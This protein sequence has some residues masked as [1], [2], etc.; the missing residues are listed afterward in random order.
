MVSVS[1][2]ADSTVLRGWIPKQPYGTVVSYYLRVSSTD[3]LVTT[4]PPDTLTPVV[5]SV[6]PDTIPPRILHEPLPNRSFRDV[7]FE[8]AATLGDTNGI[9]S[10]GVTYRIDGG[11]D[12]TVSLVQ[13]S[14][15]LWSGSMSGN[16]SPGDIVEYRI[17]ATDRSFSRNVASLPDS[18]MFSFRI[19]NSVLYDFESSDGGFQS[20]ADWQW[21][22]IATTDVPAPPHGQKVWGTN[23]SG[24][25]SSNVVSDLISPAIDLTGKTNV[26]L[27]FKHFY[28]IEP[29]NDGGNVSISVDSGAFQVVSPEGGYPWAFVAALGGPGFSGNSFVWKDARFEISGMR[30]HAIRVR[31]RFASDLLTTQRGWYVDD[32]SMDFLDTAA[33]S[34]APSAGV[35]PTAT[36]LCQNYPNPFNPTT[37]ISFDIAVGGLVRLDVY[38][39]LG[40]EVARLKHEVLAPGSYRVTFNSAGLSSGTYLCRLA[41]GSFVE[42]R[43]L[44]ILR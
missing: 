34:V 41:V 28:N 17:E 38:D 20:T 5:F 35:F 19:L 15:E 7:P 44:M 40:R 29:Q 22:T 39:V 24:N 12:T 16:F 36:R 6:V 32:F 37:V 42:T 31:M 18:G 9:A 27:T 11:P 2:Q 13:L 1:S 10:A 21:G 33:V 26:V 43:K 8:V 23:L 25:Y 4:F 14:A 3:S 30:N